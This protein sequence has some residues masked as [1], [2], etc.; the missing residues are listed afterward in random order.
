MAAEYTAPLQDMRFVLKEIVGLDRLAAMPGLEAAEAEIVDAVLE[1]AARFA[2]NVIAPTN[3]AGDQHG[4]VVEN[5]VVRT[6]P[7]FKEA[8]KQFREGGWNGVPFDPAHG[9][10]GLPW[11]VAMATQEMITAGNMAFSLCPLL[12]QGAV[13]AMAAHGSPEQQAMYLEK[14]TT[15]EWTGT[16]NL[17]EPQ[18]G[19]DVGALKARA[20]PADD[21]SWRITGTKIFITFG[22]HDMAENIIHLVLART[23]GSPPGTKGISLFVVPKFLVNADGSLGQRNDLRCVSLEHKLGIHGSPTCVMSYGD[24]GGAIGWLL[25]QENQGMKCMFTMMNNARLSVGLQGLAIAE[26]S[27][28]QALAYARERKQGR[29]LG[30]PA[31]EDVAIIQH[32][33][34]RRDL[35]TMKSNIEA[36]RALIYLNAACLDEARHHPDADARAAARARAELF[37]PLSK[38]WGTDL[39][40]ELTSIGVQIHGG[41]GFIEQTGAAQHYR[42]ARIAPIYEGTNGIQALDLLFRGLLDEMREVNK[43]I[44]TAAGLGT[45]HRHL[46]AAITASAEASEYLLEHLARDPNDASGGAVPYLRMIARTVGGWLLAKSALAALPRANGGDPFFAAKVATA[47]FYADH[48]LAQVPGLLAGARAGAANL[49]AIDTA[50]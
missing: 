31:T 49:D 37:T 33:D 16:M 20:V 3:A 28:Q 15:G 44:A 27:Y 39:G 19:S 11:A 32:A 2:R 21:G 23:P 35:M 10:G 17:T 47:R 26:R 14:L 40:V 42:D 25:G 45:M 7:G 9:G 4:S 13:E 46:G 5:G 48:V 8:Y 38:A 12:T 43:A 29:P 22:E 34:V 6:A 50:A 1:E 24:N 18:A 41:M 30:R 36:M